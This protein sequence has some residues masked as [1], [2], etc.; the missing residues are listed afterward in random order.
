MIPHK[1][2]HRV[3]Q[4]G[5]IF[6]LLVP[7]AQELHQLR[8]WQA[9]LQARYGGE[10]V[11]HIHVTS[12]R[13]TPHQ[14]QL[15]ERCVEQVISDLQGIPSF[16]LNTDMLVHF[17]AP[18]WN[19]NVLRW[20]V[21]ETSAYAE[22]RD[23]LDETLLKIDCPSHFNRQRHATCT[24]LNLDHEVDLKDNPPNRQ[25]PA[26]LFTARE[27]LISQLVEND[28]FHILETVRLK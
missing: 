24:L 20:R 16:S 25:Y 27:V 28:D 18:Y 21:Q 19:T 23:I 26:H 11:S 7:P 6:I 8:Q 17:Y 5:D 3:A 22:F 9:E 12:Q 2:T 10:P 13:F 15:E 1:P 4:P 14:G